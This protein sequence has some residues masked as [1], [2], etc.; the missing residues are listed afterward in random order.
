M[1]YFLI[2][3]LTISRKLGKKL[4]NIGEK[5]KFSFVNQFRI[6]LD[7]KLIIEKNAALILFFQLVIP[8]PVY[9]YDNYRH[10]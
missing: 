6:N 10:S 7:K 8:L 1:Q 3:Y 5:Y 4:S 2:Q 9:N